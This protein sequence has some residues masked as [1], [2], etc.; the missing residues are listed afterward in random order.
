MAQKSAEKNL[1]HPLNGNERNMQQSAASQLTNELRDAAKNECEIS[2]F[3]DASAEKEKINSSAS[4]GSQSVKSRMKQSLAQRRTALQSRNVNIPTEEIHRGDSNGLKKKAHVSALKSKKQT[5]MS[6]TVVEAVTLPV[7]VEQQQEINE[8]TNFI[9]DEDISLGASASLDSD[10]SVSSEVVDNMERSCRTA[11][12]PMSRSV[13]EEELVQKQPEQVN[14]Y[15]VILETLAEEVEMDV[16]GE[17]SHD[18]DNEEWQQHDADIERYNDELISIVHSCDSVHSKSSSR[19]SVTELEDH[20]SPKSNFVSE[21][22]SLTPANSIVTFSIGSGN[23][24]KSR[25]ESQVSGITPTGS[26]QTYSVGGR[27]LNINSNP[28]TASIFSPHLQVSDAFIM[29]NES[30]TGTDPSCSGQ[31]VI[32]DVSICNDSHI[33]PY[34]THHMLYA[35]P[36]A[37]VNLSL[38]EIRPDD[39][40]DSVLE[41]LSRQLQAVRSEKKYTSREIAASI[42]NTKGLLQTYGNIHKEV[43]SKVEVSVES[44]FMDHASQIASPVSKALATGNAIGLSRAAASSLI[45]RNKTL[46]KEVRFADQTCVELSERNLSMVRERQ[47]LDLDV[48]ELKIKNDSL[49]DAVVRASQDSARAMES[50]KDIGLKL[51]EERKRFEEELK[52]ARECVA[53]EQKRNNDLVEKQDESV[54]MASI[55]DQKIA[56]I[57]GTYKAIREE[58]IEAKATVSTL[59]DRLA[60]LEST[61]ELA[62]SAAAEKYREASSEMQRE[63]ESLLDRIDENESIIEI[64]KKARYNAEELLVD[65]KEIC[66]SLEAKHK[67]DEPKKENTAELSDSPCRSQTSKRTTSSVVLAKTLKDELEKGHEATERIIEAERIIAVTQSKLRETERD[68]RAVNDESNDLRRQLKLPQNMRNMRVPDSD[69]S[70]NISKELSVALSKR[71]ER[72]SDNDLKMKLVTAR[73][74]CEEYKR[75][76]DSI[77]SQIKGIQ[78]N[79]GPCVEANASTKGAVDSGLIDTVRDLA[80]VCT[81]VNIAAGDRVGELEVQLKFLAHS[82]NQLHEICAEDLSEVSGNSFTLEMME[83][84]TTTPIK[85]NKTPVKV[86]YLEKDEDAVSPTNTDA[87][88]VPPRD[89]TP[90]KVVRLRTQLFAAEEQINAVKDEKDSLSNA[91]DE[92]RHQIDLLTSNFQN[93]VTVSKKSEEND[94]EKATL[95]QSIALLRSLISKHEQRIESLEDDKAY[96]FDD[97]VARGD[98]LEEANNTIESL[99]EEARDAA[100]LLQ[101]QTGEKQVLRVE[102]D[103]I[104]TLS[105]ELKKN[106][107]DLERK[108]TAA[109]DTIHI[110]SSD[111][112]HNRTAIR[113]VEASRDHLQEELKLVISESEDQVTMIHDLQESVAQTTAQSEELKAS[114]MKRNE[115]FAEVVEAKV[116]LEEAKI[117]LK[118]VVRVQQI[119]LSNRSQHIQSL[120]KQ[121]GES[122]NKLCAA[123]DAYDALHEEVVNMGSQ[124]DVLCLTNDKCESDLAIAKQMINEMSSDVKFSKKALADKEQELEEAKK[125]LESAEDRFDVFENEV[126]ERNEALKREIEA[127]EDELQNLAT[128]FSGEVETN[129]QEEVKEREA[130]VKEYKTELG[131]LTGELDEANSRLEEMSSRL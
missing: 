12:S 3:K 128:H 14:T 96:L 65:F 19:Y 80:Q 115:E 15:G 17:Q 38:D 21:G 84:G 74:E 100:T 28:F 24:Q 16:E 98:E 29:E 61:G 101:S 121:G 86:L 88:L 5:E 117:E 114:F 109:N 68:L 42:A 36:S 66:D 48:E 102:L 59:R 75:E 69:N 58:H 70:D 127:K 22:S 83:E 79:N 129:L 123:E 122:Y 89:K 67:N 119:E 76:L 51:S 116:E 94:E 97:A 113:E 30:E 63:I 95:E 93:A 44:T 112:E 72:S 64:E 52:I 18:N 56:S 26:I 99:H 33:F 71:G 35:S 110:L 25:V 130:L 60:S 49:H 91:L 57:T 20:Q 8:D 11:E 131:F 73:S 77:L 31:T 7:H 39:S 111:L 50:K 90:V 40:A 125:S 1:Q 2:I 85:K 106:K 47:K 32:P 104:Q 103:S 37:K 23:S 55:S 53:R 92:A 54:K 87:S 13:S 43:E 108:L 78:T 6:T 34:P 45:E 81:R 9:A 82:M 4:V 27:S 105:Q 10:N 118:S 41:E 120:T 124:I 62:A 107:I 46:V 126:E